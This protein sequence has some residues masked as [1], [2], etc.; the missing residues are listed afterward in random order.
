M[1]SLET[2]TA[3]ER[4]FQ[5]TS[6]AERYAAAA[7]IVEVRS[8]TERQPVSDEGWAAAALCSSCECGSEAT[9]LVLVSSSRKAR[10]SSE[11]GSE[12][13]QTVRTR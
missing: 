2:A 3:I 4:C 1:W 13:A 10:S 12:S 6:Q 11:R 8:A 7:R 9:S 5:Q